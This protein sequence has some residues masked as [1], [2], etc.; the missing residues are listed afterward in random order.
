MPHVCFSMLEGWKVKLEARAEGLSVYFVCWSCSAKRA[1]SAGAINKGEEGICNWRHY[2]LRF[3]SWMHIVHFR[4]RNVGTSLFTEGRNCRRCKLVI[5]S[6][7]NTL[8]RFPSELVQYYLTLC[9]PFFLLALAFEWF[10]KSIVWRK[11]REEESKYIL[12]GQ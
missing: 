4:W 7:W 9:C 3:S 6:R 10:V 12:Y 5:S 8:M 2:Q 1:R 11:L